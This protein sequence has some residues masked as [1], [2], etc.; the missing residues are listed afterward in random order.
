MNGGQE[1][2][3]YFKGA[4]SYWVGYKNNET[5]CLLMTSRSILG[6]GISPAWKEALYKTGRTYSIDFLI[7][8]ENSQVRV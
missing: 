4:F 1:K 3:T 2:S 7:G 8:E 6:K 5:F